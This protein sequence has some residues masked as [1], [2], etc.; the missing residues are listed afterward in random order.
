MDPAVPAQPLVNITSNNDDDDELPSS[1]SA[2]FALAN[3][4]RDSTRPTFR[5][6]EAPPVIHGRFEFAPSPHRVVDQ[7]WPT[8][9]VLQP[10]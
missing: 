2:L 4:Q 6:E 10:P 5:L 7:Q 1:L 3:L 9:P 8:S